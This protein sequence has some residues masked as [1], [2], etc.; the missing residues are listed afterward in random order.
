MT[1]QSKSFIEDVND[2]KKLIIIMMP[3]VR[4][5][6]RGNINQNKLSKTILM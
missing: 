5:Q 4:K 3:N 2:V 1:N 6:K